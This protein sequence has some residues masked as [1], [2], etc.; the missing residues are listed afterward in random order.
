MQLYLIDKV[1]ILRKIS[2]KLHQEGKR[3]EEKNAN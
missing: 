1:E 2:G 3:E